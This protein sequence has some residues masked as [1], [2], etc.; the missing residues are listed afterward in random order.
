VEVP[1]GAFPLA[2]SITTE[3][4]ITWASAPPA[5]GYVFDVQIKRPGGDWTDWM[6]AQTAQSATFVPDSGVGDYSFRARY[7]NIANAK[8]SLWSPTISISVV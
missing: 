3:F 6:T 5:A 1:V 8:T 7:N 4:T 2:G